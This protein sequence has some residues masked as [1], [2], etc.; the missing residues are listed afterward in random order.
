MQPILDSSASGIPE[1]TSASLSPVPVPATRLGRYLIAGRIA[2]GGMATVFLARMEASGGFSREFAL[3]VIHPHLVDQ[4]GFRERFHREARL[5]SRVRHPNVV[6]TIDA[7]E[8]AGY[9]YMA[10]ELIEGGTLRQLMLQRG[11][12]FPPVEAAQLIAEVARGLHA[13]HSATDEAGTP[14]NVVHRDLSPHNLML[15]RTGRPVLI[16][17][18]LA[19]ADDTP[20]LTQIGM[21]AG[22]LPYMSPE[23][24][25]SDAVDARSDVFA[26][27]SVLC[28]MAT[29]LPPFG[30]RHDTETLDRLQRGDLR[31]VAAR[32]RDAGL[33]QWLSE[34]IMLCLQPN[35]DD[36]FATAEALA[37]ALAQ[38]LTQAGYRVLETR[39]RLARIVE[40]ALPG[41]GTLASMH[42]LPPRLQRDP[43]QPVAMV[44]GDHAP[45][46]RRRIPAAAWALSGAVVGALLF[47]GILVLGD[48][49][50]EATADS[51]T[52]PSTLAP[53]TAPRDTPDGSAHQP[54]P[55]PE[56]PV[57][58]PAE[59]AEIA[60]DSEGETDWGT[61]SGTDGDSGSGTD[62]D[63]T[64][65]SQPVSR[66][67]RR[68]ARPREDVAELKPNPYAAQ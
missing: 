52:T 57:R 18:G 51:K 37:D 49:G 10:L 43:S 9:C 58:P 44:T 12:G 13:L 1:P 23:Q 42:S 67:R 60:W 14:L 19:K 6:T 53:D 66:R 26:L 24:A 11:R 22:R 38:E 50:D 54:Q 8:D 16:D 3:K 21:L 30:D 64:S 59:P 35:P 29:G 2:T 5:A 65:G 20:A 4:P 39:Q 46:P 17:L 47:G 31:P 25:R 34:I 28:E 40:Q 41:L 27:G 61:G 7:G 63:T 15:D 33:P 55:P 56:V 68:V 45:V 62:G 32:L 48:L 36:R